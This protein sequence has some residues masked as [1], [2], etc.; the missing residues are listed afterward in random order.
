MG[1]CLSKT[2]VPYVPFSNSYPI[3]IEFSSFDDPLEVYVSDTDTIKD[4]LNKLKSL[5]S[6]NTYKHPYV[7]INYLQLI[8]DGI[9]LNHHKTLKHYTTMWSHSVLH[10]EYPKMKFGKCDVSLLNIKDIAPH[11]AIADRFNT[12][13]KQYDAQLFEMYKINTNW[14]TNNDIF[15]VVLC[16]KENKKCDYLYH[17]TSFPNVPKIITNGF[18]RDYNRRSVYGYGTY[19]AKSPALAS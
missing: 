7:P 3:T 10:A 16:T 18:N 4:I 8:L 13:M 17:G 19:L 11:R 2:P 14:D 15:D 12:D 5:N 1:K 9:L 6:F